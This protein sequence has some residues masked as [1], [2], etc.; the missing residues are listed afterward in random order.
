VIT[1]DK[2]VNFLTATA[3]RLRME[4]NWLERRIISYNCIAVTF[5]GSS[6][7]NAIRQILYNDR[8]GRRTEPL[9]LFVSFIY[10]YAS[11]ELT[12]HIEL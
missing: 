7:S 2:K 4:S 6:A 9:H 10:K 8:Q 12:A 11:I 3:V 1:R 5:Q